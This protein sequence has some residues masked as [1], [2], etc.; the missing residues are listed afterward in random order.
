MRADS[1]GSGPSAQPPASKQTTDLVNALAK[2]ERNA[3]YTDIAVDVQF[4]VAYVADRRHGL[5]DGV[6]LLSTL[7]SRLFPTS[8]ALAVVVH[9]K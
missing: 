3:E 1:S 6:S 9:S 5:A 4:A 2:L 7:V 8:R